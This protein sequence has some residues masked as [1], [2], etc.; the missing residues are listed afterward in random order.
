MQKFTALA[1]VTFRAGRFLLTPEQ[2]A[3]RKYVVRIVDGLA[4]PIRE[5]SFKAGEVIETDLDVPKAL[6]VKLEP[7]VDAPAEVAFTVQDGAESP[8]KRGR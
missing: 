8:R 2:L 6:H 7:V 4:E 3:N 5:I 1:P